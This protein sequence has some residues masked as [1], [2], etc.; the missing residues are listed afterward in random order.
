VNKDTPIHKLGETVNLQFRT[1]IFN[2]LNH[3]NFSVPSATV[4]TQT[5]INPT[6]GLIGATTTPAR[7]VQ[8]ALKVV[9]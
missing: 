2:V 7:Q 5:G 9:F 3:P 4:L 1:E 6:A 8:L